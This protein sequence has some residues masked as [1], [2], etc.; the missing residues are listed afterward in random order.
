MTGVGPSV[1]LT[2]RKYRFSAPPSSKASIRAVIF[3]EEL[4]QLSAERTLVPAGKAGQC[5]V[6]FLLT[7][8]EGTSTT[9]KCELTSY[10]RFVEWEIAAYNH[11]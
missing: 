2:F 1:I 8:F 5:N 7:K 3:H 4:P 11:D 9:K 6:H 10:N